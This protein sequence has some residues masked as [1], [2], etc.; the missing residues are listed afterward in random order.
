MAEEAIRNSPEIR[1]IDNTL[2]AR[3]EILKGERRQL[4]PVEDLVGQHS[5]DPGEAALVA[6]T[7]ASLGMEMPAFERARSFGAVS[8]M[9]TRS[10]D[11]PLH[12]R[13]TTI[14]ESR[15]DFERYWSSDE[16]ARAREDAMPYYVKP[17]LPSWHVPADR[18]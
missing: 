1:S 15:E 12:F 18:D 8:A 5:A 11:D 17:L 16:A 7:A 3:D 6:D 14:W 9:M 4:G 2:R 10:E 13:Q